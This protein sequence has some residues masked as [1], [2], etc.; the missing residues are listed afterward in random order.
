MTEHTVCAEV[1]TMSG[2]LLPPAVLVDRGEVGCCFNHE[3]VQEITSTQSKP[4]LI[5]FLIHFI[6]FHFDSQLIT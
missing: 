4:D 3:N 1:S 2:I 5:S 6:F